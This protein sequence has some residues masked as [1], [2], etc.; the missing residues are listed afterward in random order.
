MSVRVRVSRCVCVRV[1]ACG[2]VC[3]MTCFCQ[4]NFA[5]KGS[6]LCA[7]CDKTN[8]NKETKYLLYVH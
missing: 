4:V 3:W 5:I 8:A 1:C 2:C 6:K 7:A